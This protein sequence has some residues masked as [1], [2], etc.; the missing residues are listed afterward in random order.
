MLERTMMRSAGPG[1]G[2]D[3]LLRSDRPT[4]RGIFGLLC[5][6]ALVSMLPASK[7]EAQCLGFSRLPPQH[8]D[9]VIASGF[10]KAFI[11]HANGVERIVLQPSYRG[12]AKDFGVFLAVP[13]IP[14]IEK[15]DGRLFTELERLVAPPPPMQRAKRAAAAS[16]ESAD[17]WQGVSVIKQELVGI[18]EASV[19]QAS[20]RS[21]FTKW[22][23]ANGYKWPK[24]VEPVFDHY[25]AAKWFFVAMK[26][27]RNVKQAVRFDGPIQPVSVRF[28]QDDI[29][30]PMKLTS[31]TPGGV[32]FVYYLITDTKIEA[33]NIDASHLKFTKP[34]KETAYPRGGTPQLTK[35]L[36]ED[37]LRTRQDDLA[38]VLKPQSSYLRRRLTGRLWLTKYQGHFNARD[39]GE[40]FVWTPVSP[41]RIAMEKLFEGELAPGERAEVIDAF[42]TGMRRIK[43]VVFS[44][45]VFDTNEGY[46]K[47]TF[48]NGIHIGDLAAIGGEGS[49]VWKTIE[50]DVPHSVVHWLGEKVRIKVDNYGLEKADGKRFLD[51]YNIR[52]V[53]IVVE[54]DNGKTWA[55][56]TF[57]GTKCS[58]PK[59]KA[60]QGD[61]VAKWGAPVVIDF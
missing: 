33:K 2:I 6:T 22:L 36:T 38:E 27:N 3:A 32:D 46:G 59:W 16:V 30:M 21:S 26:V 17:S 4:P 40:D 47:P 58:I 25:V 37:V 39:L 54:Y 29:L 13:E 14:V 31:P 53:R 1:S 56:K 35:Y 24:A 19:L 42:K 43:R 20:D 51:A 10:Q 12:K 7:A 18:Y 55:S 15:A 57:T 48:I 61:P 44:A 9:A 8:R 49:N 45:E 11:Y 28:T 60:C 34:L 41:G 52:N 5:F 23:K 50:I